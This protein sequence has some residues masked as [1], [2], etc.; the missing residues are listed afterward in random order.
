[1]ELL[2]VINQKGILES[3]ITN[4]VREF[5]KTTGLKV[6]GLIFFRPIPYT[7][8]FTGVEPILVTVKVEISL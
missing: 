6:S 7:G 5:E 4:L 3:N 8:G 2:E 1:M